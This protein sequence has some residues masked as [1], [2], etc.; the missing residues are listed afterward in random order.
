MPREK[1]GRR[2]RRMKLT[3]HNRFI[4]ALFVICTDFKY[5]LSRV[6]MIASLIN[7]NSTNHV[8]FVFTS[9]A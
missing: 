5:S 2:K 4:K 3:N 9:F 7:I 6:V 8:V 1:E